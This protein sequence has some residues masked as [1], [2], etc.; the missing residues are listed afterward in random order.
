MVVD[1]E[2]ILKSVDA[3]PQGDTGKVGYWTL[4]T[5][6]EIAVL[7]YNQIAQTTG[8]FDTYLQFRRRFY[9][10]PSAPQKIDFEG[11]SADQQTKIN[12]LSNKFERTVALEHFRLLNLKDYETALHTYRQAAANTDWIRSTFDNGLAG[13]LGY[14]HAKVSELAQAPN[15]VGFAKV[16][17][18]FGKAK[19]TL[20]IAESTARLGTFIVGNHGSGKSEIIKHRI[21]HYLTKDKPHETIFLIDPHGELATEVAR[22]KPLYGSDRLVVFD[23]FLMDGFLPCLSILNT[24]NKHPQNLAF[25]AEV[26]GAALERVSGGEMSDNMTALC[27][28]SAHVIL[29]D[30]R[31]NVL[32]LMRLVK[33]APPKKG[34]PERPYPDAYK[35]AA[36]QS[37]NF[38]I[39]EFFQDNFMFGNFAQAK[40]GLSE[41][42]T[43]VLTSPIAQQMFLNSPTID[44]PSLVN[45]GKVVIIRLPMQGL[46]DHVTAMIGQMIVAQIQMAVMQRDLEQIAKYPQVHL[47]MDEAHHFVSGNTAKQID[48]LRK[49]KFSLTLATQYTEKFPP[50][51]LNSVLALGV[52]IAGLCVH[53]NLTTMNEAFGLKKSAKE[54]ADESRIL[55]ELDVGNF[56]FKSRTTA[57]QKK[58]RTR[59]FQTDTTLLFNN[60][61]WKAK[62]ADRFMSDD[63]WEQTKLDQI[64]KYYRRMEPANSVETVDET[65]ITISKTDEAIE[66]EFAT[67]KPVLGFD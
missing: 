49:F 19:R 29:E 23:P 37:G 24:K 28:R 27:E 36:K 41:R 50:A 46:G 60:P 9:T 14:A 11:L 39:R 22:M 15:M 31:F 34:A 55:A 12:K 53:K 64:G 35:F 66:E 56:F 51:I 63:E 48:E 42:L 7:V 33:V 62:N 67:I 13:Y 18:E 52:Q 16:L 5:A 26:Y 2:K 17:Q 30:D 1:L 4:E 47:F 61:Q 20:P 40:N 25:E 38:I 43:R 65:D 32:D 45:S 3:F 44:F 21:W 10:P 59:Q 58:Q 8:H 54:D 6:K 57:G